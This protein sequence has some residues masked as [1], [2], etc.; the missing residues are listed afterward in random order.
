MTEV[1]VGGVLGQSRLGFGTVYK[2]GLCLPI[3]DMFF[4][5]LVLDL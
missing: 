4:I 5:F 2:E 3:E 1:R